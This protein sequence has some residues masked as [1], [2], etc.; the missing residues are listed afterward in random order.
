MF[1]ILTWTAG[2]QKLYHVQMKLLRDHKNH[3]IY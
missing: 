3:K 1:C 2:E